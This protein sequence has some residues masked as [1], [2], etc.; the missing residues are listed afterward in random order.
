MDVDLTI[1]YSDERLCEIVASRPDSRST[2]LTGLSPAARI[3][4]RAS[5][6][7]CVKLVACMK[8]PRG[9]IEAGEAM[10]DPKQ[11]GRAEEKAKFSAVQ[12]F[13]VSF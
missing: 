12:D 10:L 9:R 11:R 6:K 13:Q 1:R 5:P 3:S 4:A 7:R 8:S 2:A